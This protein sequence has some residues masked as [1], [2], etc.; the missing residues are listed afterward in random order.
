MVYKTHIA[1]VMMTNSYVFDISEP[2]PLSKPHYRTFIL[3]SFNLFH[4]FKPQTKYFRQISNIRGT[5][6]PHCIRNAQ[7]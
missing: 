7:Q 4:G 2:A 3:N 6:L 1:F 5:A